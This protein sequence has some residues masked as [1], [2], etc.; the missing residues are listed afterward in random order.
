MAR[1]KRVYLE[2]VPQHI[3]QKFNFTLTPIVLFK[4]AAKAWTGLEV[5]LAGDVITSAA[6][7]IS[8][9][10]ITESG[11][12]ATLTNADRVILGDIARLPT[13]TL[14]GDAREVVVNNYFMRNG[15]TPLEGK[16]GANCFDGVFVKG[17]KVYIVETK[18]LNANGTIKLSGPVK[19]ANGVTTLDTQMSEKW[20]NYGF[21]RLSEGTLQMQQTAALIKQAKEAGNLIKVVAGANSKGVTMV[22][23]K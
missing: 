11:I 1:L 23:L 4:L 18:T 7:N 6:G 20:V 16:C 14:Q 12:Q 22:K 2:D 10:Q 15:F 5:K 21:D 19:N 3:I 13:T 17:D 8:A 9:K